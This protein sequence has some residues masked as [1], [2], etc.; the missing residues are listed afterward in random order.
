[1]GKKT[2]IDDGKAVS[3]KVIATQPYVKDNVHQTGKF[4]WSGLLQYKVRV[5]GYQ[6]VLLMAFKQGEAPADGSMIDVAICVED[7]KWH[8]GYLPE[9]LEKAK[10]GGGGGRG[11]DSKHAGFATVYVAH[12]SC[13][14]KEGMSFSEARKAAAAATN[15][16]FKLMEV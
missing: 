10:S 15:E 3:R 5:D 9:Q 14:L 13:F 2:W 6:N 11:S 12:L 4:E 7:E 1:M 8:K 16:V